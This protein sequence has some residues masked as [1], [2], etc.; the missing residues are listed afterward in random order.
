MQKRQSII[1]T[2][3]SALC[4][5]LSSCAGQ[6]KEPPVAATTQPTTSPTIITE[7]AKEPPE[8]ETNTPEPS[9]PAISEQQP[10]C[11]LIEN[12]GYEYYL[13][14]NP[15]SEDKDTNT[16]SLQKLT[17]E[18]NGIIDTELWFTDN[19][20]TH[21]APGDIIEDTAYFYHLS[22]E[23]GSYAYMLN[24]YTKENR[25][26]LYTLDFS[27]YRYTDNPSEEDKRFIEQRIKWVKSVD[28][29]LYV[30]VG[31]DTYTKSSPH[32]GYLVAVDL[33]DKSV[34]WKSEPCVTNAYTFEIIDNTIVCGYGFTE[35]PDYLIL[36]NRLD[37]IITEKI[38]I[39]S[40]AEYIIQK[41]DIL[42]IRTYNTNY[43]FQ[44]HKNSA[45]QT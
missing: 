29:I 34:L 42:Y 43:T 45:S 24:L 33:T 37:G 10:A 11:F 19:N 17:E 2:V 27:E 26:F 4:L 20:L 8:T 16:I 40:M 36:I 35:E 21:P 31:H 9:T 41:D 6:P 44:I 1:I 22:G 25:E 5:F 38:P 14:P 7:P 30:A 12:P 3:L 32:T 28:N 18:S 13:K 23:D 39:A 15:P